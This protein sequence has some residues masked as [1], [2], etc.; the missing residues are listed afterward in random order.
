MLVTTFEN[1]TSELALSDGGI[2]LVVTGR[3]DRAG[4]T[5]ALS[6]Y[7]LSP[8]DSTIVASLAEQPVAH[9]ELC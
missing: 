6:A 8:A 9:G 2:R 7:I 5:Y 3:V 4:E 1:R